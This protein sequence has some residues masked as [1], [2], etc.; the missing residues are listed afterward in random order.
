MGEKDRTP[1]I[2][3]LRTGYENSSSLGADSGNNSEQQQTQTEGASPN[4]AENGNLENTAIGVS[5]NQTPAQTTE[6]SQSGLDYDGIMQRANDGQIIESLREQVAALQRE[7]ARLNEQQ[8]TSAQQAQEAV[9]E[10]LAGKDS[11]PVFDSDAYAFASDEERQRMMTEYTNSVVDY[12]TQKATSAMLEKMS[13]LMDDYESAR[14][15]E[16]LER[17]FKQLKGVG[18]FSDIDE[19]HDDVMRICNRQEFNGMKPH[20]RVTLAAL[21]SRALKSSPAAEQKDIGTRAEEIY[22]DPELM[23]ALE[24]LKAR[25]IQENADT[26]PPQSTGGGLNGAAY[27]P[28][29]KP[30]SIEELR[31]MYGAY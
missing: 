10:V 12:A 14:R 25:N 6:M 5:Q 21:V 27:V 17:A 13:P 19:Y 8:S 15:S 11:A 20:Q 18:G 28:A 26:Y 9:A 7:N 4:G 30:Q 16:E 31:K 22:K 3:D 29:Q 1:T 24:T 2:E 23:K